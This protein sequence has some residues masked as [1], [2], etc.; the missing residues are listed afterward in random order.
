M[1]LSGSLADR[2]RG[3][4]RVPRG[5]AAFILR[6]KPGKRPRKGSRAGHFAV[7]SRFESTANND[8]RTI[9]AKLRTLSRDQLLE[10]YHELVDKRFEGALEYTELFELDRIAVR[11]DADSQAEV[12]ALAALKS[13]WRRERSEL[14]I[15]IERLLA[16]VKAAD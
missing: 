5:K 10:R 7:T 12:S 13:D 2:G 15:S 1:R 16:R 3:E 6:R 8:A 14:L 11:L 4:S 9:E